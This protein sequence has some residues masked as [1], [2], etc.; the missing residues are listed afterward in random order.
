MV[1]IES[2][3]QARKLVREAQT[4]ANEE[5]AQRERDNVD[6]LATFRVART[7]FAGVEGWHAGRVPDRPGS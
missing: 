1:K 4:R 2:K 7:R 3:D 5:R 6:D